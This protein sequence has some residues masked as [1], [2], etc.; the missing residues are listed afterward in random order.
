MVDVSAYTRQSRTYEPNDPEIRGKR[1]RRFRLDELERFPREVRDLHRGLFRIM[2]ELVFADDFVGKVRK[3]LQQYTEM[4]IDLWLHSMRVVGRTKLRSLIPGASFIAV[5]GLPPLHEKVLLE[6][7]LR[8]CY[9]VVDALLGGRGVTVDIH[10]PLTEIEH[11]VFSFL[12]LKVLQLFYGDLTNP[13]QMAVRLEDMRNDLKS[14]ADIVRHDDFWMVASWKM[15]FDLDVG[16]VRALMPTSLARKIVTEYPPPGS[17]LQQRMHERIRQR[18][19]RLAGVTV[20]AP[21]EVGRIE[22]SQEDIDQLDPGDIILLEN[23]TVQLSEEGVY[24]TATMTIGLGENGV[25]H[26]NV[27][28][29]GH[30]DPPQ[31]VFEVTQIEI[32]QQPREHDPQII[33]G[34]HGNPEEVMAEY[35]APPADAEGYEEDYYDEA[36]DGS[37]TPDDVLDED[38]G[39]DDEDHG[40]DEEYGDYEEGYAEEGYEEGYAEEGY[41]EGYAEDGQGQE[42]D[43]GGGEDIPIDDS[44]N[45]MEAEPL[46]GDMPIHVVVE[47]GRVQLTA[48][49]VIRLRAGT[50]LEL[51]RSPADPVDLV[52]NGKLL[53]KGE[54]VEIEGA[55]GVKILNLV[56]ET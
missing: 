9:R 36:D 52:V 18:M 16:Y 12:L 2:P 33:H 5:I 4:D 14:C 41:E 25:V 40:E 13:E 46:L 42:Y 38:W 53:A 7:D 1:V 8:F 29:G 28:A 30:M 26:G 45:L 21:V 19:Y 31:L 23:C 6:I 43:E 20:E 49:E 39:I 24:G 3:V 56:K 15:N 54:L 34:E 48:D 27:G 50:L 17:V 10:R 47:L 22:L 32:R 35:E 11:G 51:G 44:D 37:T 55:L